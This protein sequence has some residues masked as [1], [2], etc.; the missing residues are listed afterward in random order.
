[1]SNFFGSKKQLNLTGFSEIEK[2][3]VYLDTYQNRKLGRVGMPYKKS[4]DVRKNSEDKKEKKVDVSKMSDSKVIS[5]IRRSEIVKTSTNKQ[6]DS[7][8]DKM[9]LDIDKSKPLKEK[10]QDFVKSIIDYAELEGSNKEIGE[11]IDEILESDDFEPELAN[12]DKLDKIISNI[13][14]F[15]DIKE[16]T[17]DKFIDSY[18]YK[19]DKK[20]PLEDKKREIVNTIIKTSDLKGTNKELSSQVSEILQEG[21]ENI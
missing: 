11:S 14:I 16:K 2:G 4:T 13:D 3:G 9:G 5:I 10:K 18:E 1:M 7:F 15:T 19:I 12:R 21:F 17:V 8:I 20:L 6:I